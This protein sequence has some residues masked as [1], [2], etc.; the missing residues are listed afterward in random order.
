MADS[1]RREVFAEF[2]GTFVLIAFGVGV[3]AQ[4]ALGTANIENSAG[5]SLAQH[6]FGDWLSINIG[7]GVAVMLAIYVA[8]GVS[9]AHINPA[10]TLALAVTRRFSWSKTIPYMAAQF[11]GALLAS[12][13]VFV[14]YHEAILAR[15]VSDG[16]RTLATAGI[17]ATYPQQ[18]ASGN[19]LSNLGGLIDQVVGTALLVLCVVAIGDTRNLAPKA[20]LAPLAVG[21]VVLMIGMAFGSNCG[22]AI[23]PARDLSPRLFTFVAGWGAQVFQQPNSVWWLV[24]IAGPFAGGVVGAVIYDQLIGRLHPPATDDC[25]SGESS[26]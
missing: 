6:N 25:A 4:V 21:S 15:E 1:L 9:G 16:G 10:I 23:N 14:V 19:T 11:A 12:A 5:A 2:L 24:P 13:V 17:W 18:F 3:N 8:G 22:Y 26:E 20:N 7:W